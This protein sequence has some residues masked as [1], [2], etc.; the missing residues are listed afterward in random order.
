MAWAVERLRRHPQLLSRRTEEVDA[1]GSELRQA[2]IWEVQRASPVLDGAMRRTKT[3]IRLGEWVLPENANLILSI[4]LAHDSEESFPNAASFDPDRFIGV[5]QKPVAWIPFGGGVNRCV[6]AA[7]A[8]MEMDVA[9]RILLREFRFA[10]AD[11]PGERRR[12][13]GVANAPARGAR[14]LVYRRTPRREEDQFAGC[15]GRR[16]LYGGFLGDAATP[17][18]SDKQPRRSRQ[19]S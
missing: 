17:P 9:L 7:F 8:N 15:A 16:S 4:R 10:P 2:T 19:R 1:G 12:W 14:A 13:R 11:A 5:V 6:G 18:L 3:R